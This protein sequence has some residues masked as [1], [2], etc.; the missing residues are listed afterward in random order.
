MKPNRLLFIVILILMCTCPALCDDKEDSRIP[1]AAFCYSDPQSSQEVRFC[2]VFMST[3]EKSKKFRA[4][5][6]PEPAMVWNIIAVDSQEC[7]RMA[8]SVAIVLHTAQ[9]AGFKPIVWQKAGLIEYPSFKKEMEALMTVGFEVIV[10]WLPGAVEASKNVCQ[11][12]SGQ[13]KSVGLC[14][15]HETD[16]ELSKMND[17]QYFEVE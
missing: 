3:F 12:K 10:T 5:V 11:D 6:A 4:A 17:T 2:K 16:G 9:L 13:Y 15:D 8:Y 7:E 1:T 14:H